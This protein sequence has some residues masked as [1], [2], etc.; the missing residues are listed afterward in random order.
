MRHA[1]EPFKRQRTLL[2]TAKAENA[3]ARRHF[4][5]FN[6]LAVLDRLPLLP[7]AHPYYSDMQKVCIHHVTLVAPYTP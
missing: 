5:F 7:T 6:W 4:Q 2:G 3:S 1:V